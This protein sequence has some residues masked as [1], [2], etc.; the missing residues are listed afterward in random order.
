M[1]EWKGSTFQRVA[2]NARPYVGHA[3][4]NSLRRAAVAQGKG[5]A[6]RSSNGLALEGKAD[7]N[8]AIFQ[9]SFHK[10]T[11]SIERI[12]KNGHILG[13]ECRRF[14]SHIVVKQVSIQGGHVVIV[15]CCCRFAIVIIFL[16]DNIQLIAPFL[17]QGR[18]NGLMCCLISESQG[19]SGIV[20]VF[21]LHLQ[22]ILFFIFAVVIAVVAVPQRLFSCRLNFANL[23]APSLTS[24]HARGQ[25]LTD[26]KGDC[27][28]VAKCCSCSCGCQQQR[29]YDSVPG[30][31]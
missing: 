2:Q 21:E 22:I 14:F 27:R 30:R 18:H 4:N 15:L 29:Y 17:A 8:L 16:A 7:Q 12:D 20:G 25:E 5:Q 11:G 31:L 1:I 23:V 13:I 9:S 24:I 3:V 26:G 19:R 10:F 6:N 28:A